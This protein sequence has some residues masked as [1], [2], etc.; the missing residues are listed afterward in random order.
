MSNNHNKNA[1]AH[2]HRN[3]EQIL[4]RRRN[5]RRENRTPITGPRYWLTPTDLYA[6][7][8]AKYNFDF[9]PCPYPRPDGYN[10]LSSKVTWGKSNYVN[11]PFKLI[12]APFGG[13]AKFADRAIA[14]SKRGKKSVFVLPVATGVAKL[15]AAGGRVVGC[16]KVAFLEKDTHEPD[17][18]SRWQVIIEIGSND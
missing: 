9:D 14:E 8:N 5:A 15:L 17:P 7:L 1:R 6:R 2:Y 11:P 12:D 18:V 13:I 16:E 4:Q 10:S 3:R